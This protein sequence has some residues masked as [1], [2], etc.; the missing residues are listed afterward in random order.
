LFVFDPAA[1]I[2][3]RRDVPISGMTGN[4]V[5]VTDGLQDG[6]RIVTAGVAFLRDGQKAR[7]WSSPE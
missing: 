1:Q 3:K 7:L 6:D 5:F 4:R 2:V